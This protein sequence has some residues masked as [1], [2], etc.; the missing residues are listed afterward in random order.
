MAVSSSYVQR[1]ILQFLRLLIHILPFSNQNADQ[2]Q[3]S[4]LAGS[5]NIY[6]NYLSFILRVNPFLVSGFLAMLRAVLF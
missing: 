1:T 2:I 5:P 4:L 3:L 6:T